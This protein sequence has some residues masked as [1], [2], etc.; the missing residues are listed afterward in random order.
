MRSQTF[1]RLEIET[2][3]NSTTLSVTVDKKKKSNGCIH[4]KRNKH[5]TETIIVDVGGSS[6]P[7]QIRHHCMF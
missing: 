3:N 5:K 4:F 7:T 6:P 1:E 2:L